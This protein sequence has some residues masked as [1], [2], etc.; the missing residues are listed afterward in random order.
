M[1]DSVSAPAAPA[2]PSA[3]SSPAPAAKNATPA[4]SAGVSGAAPVTTKPLGDVTKP[5][6]TEFQKRQYKG[7]VDKQERVWELSDEEVAVRLQKAEAAESR[8]QK[9]SDIQKKWEQLQQIA[10]ED[11]S[12]LIREL[13]GVDPQEYAQRLVEEKWKLEVMPEHDRK[14]YELEK[15][16]KAY[17]DQEAKAN[18]AREHA[19][20]TQAEK[21]AEAQLEATFQRAFEVSGL[22]YNEDNLEVFGQLVLANHD[23]G[24][25]YTPEQLAAEARSRIDERNQKYEGKV[26]ERFSGLKGPELLDFLGEAAVKE[27]LRAAVAR[28]TPKVPDAP[29]ALPANSGTEA[30]GRDESGKFAPKKYLTTA[31]WRKAFG[32]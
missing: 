30:Q 17:Q 9:A 7:K 27:V 13:A 1:S 32:K 18:A 4:P 14:V 23:H 5:A 8:F 22:E 31:D 3:P 28:H 10:K 11:P 29:A 15:K 19:A 6:P 26:K 20:K 24:L 12:L 21:A 16:I 2:A 25:E